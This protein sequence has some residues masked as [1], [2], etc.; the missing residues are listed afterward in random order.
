MWALKNIERL[1]KAAEDRDAAFGTLSSWILY[2]LSNRR[3]HIADASTLSTSGL[4]DTFALK[5]SPIL[6][7]TYGIPEHMLPTMVDAIGPLCV[8]DVFGSP[9]PITA[10]VSFKK[11]VQKYSNSFRSGGGC[12]RFYVWIKVL[13]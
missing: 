1:K 2:K 9:I 13:Q 11:L 8:T 3:V 12:K 4:F 6:L 7:N 5:W 10:C